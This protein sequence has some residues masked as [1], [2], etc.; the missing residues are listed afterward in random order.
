MK[1]GYDCSRN[2]TLV[3]ACLAVAVLLGAAALPAPVQAKGKARIAVI[4]AESSPRQDP[5]RA[6]YDFAR[7]VPMMES[8][9]EKLLGLFEQA[10]EMGA[11][12]VCGPE[13]MQHI[14]AYGLYLNTRNPETGEIL[15][16]S[17]A[18]PVPGP[19]TGRIAQIARRF[20]MYVIA[21]LYER[22]GDKIYNTSVVFGRNGKI[23]GKH[24][25][26]VLPVLETWLV[27]QGDGFEVFPLDFGNVAVAACLELS[28]PEIATIYAL[29][30][31][32]II[33][34]PT[35]A[36]ENAPGQSLRT[37]HRYLTR[38][39]DN[40]VYIAPVI[41]GSDGNGI[42]DSQGQVVAEA[43]GKKNT[44]IM[45]EIDFSRE[46]IQSGAW[47]PA[48]NGADNKKA[49]L[50]LGRR[51]ETFGAIVAPHSPLLERYK[52]V[53]LTTGDREAQI[54]AVEKVDYGP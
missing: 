47:W 18:V 20:S 27:E 41:L 33:F 52:D 24:R 53:R 28:Y 30:G 40:Y 44:V 7:V 2:R 22:D 12:L 4:Q 15:F 38:A 11:D 35:M 34:N 25:K 16:N 10:G 21:P 48:I 36:R 39:S 9:L 19:L 23:I 32:D 43:V 31:A 42:V 51:P 29:K 49:I 45:A 8:H 3:A 13:D 50:F 14:G 26:T 46:P 5:F 54:K 1:L 37:G 6:E 17:L